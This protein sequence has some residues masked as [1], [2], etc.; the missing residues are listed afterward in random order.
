MMGEKVH[1]QYR[2][3]RASAEAVNATLAAIEY[4]RRSDPQGLDRVLFCFPRVETV[5]GPGWQYSSAVITAA[6]AIAL[7]PETAVDKNL[8]I[9]RMSSSHPIP[10]VIVSL[11]G[12]LRLEYRVSRQSME[13]LLKAGCLV[14]SVSDNKQQVTC[15]I[16]TDSYWQFA[17][18]LL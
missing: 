17:L 2:D 6:I 15:R 13:R 7:N 12:I 5:H 8:P 18:G 16:P 9:Q 3:A 11:S 10:S 14:L 1:I 4:A